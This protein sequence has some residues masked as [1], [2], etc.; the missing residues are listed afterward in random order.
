LFL[1]IEAKVNDLKVKVIRGT[2][3]RKFDIAVIK[4][5]PKII[6]LKFPLCAVYTGFYP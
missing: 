4:K 6:E 5:H 3:K 2:I 1:Q